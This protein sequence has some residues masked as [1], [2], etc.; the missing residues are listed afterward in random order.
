MFGRLLFQYPRILAAATL[1][2]IDDERAFLQCY[3]S[4]ASRHNIDFVS[5]KDVRTKIH[6][7]GLE[8]VAY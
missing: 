1:G 4:Q 5:I 7:P 8:M 3:A 2:G 6:M